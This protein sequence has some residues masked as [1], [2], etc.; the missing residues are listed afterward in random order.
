MQTHDWSPC[1][2]RLRRRLLSRRAE[3]GPIFIFPQPIHC[4]QFIEE[5]EKGILDIAIEYNVRSS[6]RKNN[7]VES[8]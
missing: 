8:I 5:E 6:R 1:R 2:E 7:P 4:V 3:A